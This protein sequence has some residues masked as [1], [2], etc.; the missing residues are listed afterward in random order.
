[1]REV[2]A[3][4]IYVAKARAEYMLRNIDQ[5]A[6]SATVWQGRIESKTTVCPP[7]ETRGHR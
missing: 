1:M 4:E 5:A 7:A 2:R 3:Q 6:E